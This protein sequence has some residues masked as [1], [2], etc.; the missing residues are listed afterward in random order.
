MLVAPAPAPAFDSP[1]AAAFPATGEAPPLAAFPV[2]LASSPAAAAAASRAPVVDG[3]GKVDVRERRDDV[4][5][6]LAARPATVA[7]LVER[8]LLPDAAAAVA[9]DADA[10]AGDGDGAGTVAT[11]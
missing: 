9:T 6:N 8:M 4:L 7:G 1:Q 2:L 5:D 10:D 11:S 3:I